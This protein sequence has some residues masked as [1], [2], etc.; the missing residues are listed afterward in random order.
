VGVPEAY[1]YGPERISWIATMLTNWAGDHGFMEELY[2]E[3]RRF[4]LV[5]DLTYCIGTVVAKEP[6]EKGLG[7]IKL[8]VEARDQRDQLTAK[9]WAQVLLPMRAG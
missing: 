1:D 6:A 8:S 9:G 3:I 2:T 4:N 7:R 5:G